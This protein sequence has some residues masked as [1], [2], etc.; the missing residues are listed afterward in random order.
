M[1]SK[2]K[3]DLPITA[4]DFGLDATL[5]PALEESQTPAFMAKEPAWPAEETAMTESMPGQGTADEQD[6]VESFNPTIGDDDG[7][8]WEQLVNLSPAV[9][10]DGGF[11]PLHFDDDEWGALNAAPAVSESHA[12]LHAPAE[13]EKAEPKKAEAEKVKALETSS[14]S[15]T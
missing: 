1:N 12:E 15:P 9:G 2:P 6:A 11:V 8:L 4:S 13:A 10:D 7:F 14:R 3:N 5:A